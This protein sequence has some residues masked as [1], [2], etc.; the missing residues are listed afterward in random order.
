MANKKVNL[1][2]IGQVT[3]YKN[4]RSRSIRIKVRSNHDTLVT[5]PH[6]MPYKAAL[7]FVN[8]Q[9]DWIIKQQQQAAVLVDKQ[10]IG[11]AHHLYFRHDQAAN[12]VRSRVNQTEVIVTLPAQ[13]EYAG[14]LAQSTAYQA[15]IKA[16]KNESQT[17]LPQRL[18]L[19][20]EGGSFVYKDVHT[21]NL[22]SRWGSCSQDNT[23]GLN[24]F[25]M[26][27]PW[28]LIDYV[29]LHELAHTRV[30]NHS[31]KF[32]DE[33]SKYAP[34][35]KQLRRQLHSFHPDFNY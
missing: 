22:K 35:Y 14:Q 16:L 17:L 26:K 11:K 23:I 8:S 7:N 27:L 6:W 30:H 20:A 33:L 32:W 2:L 12:S 10:A 21:R 29:L 24:I 31:S 18:R 15:C 5:L 34:N 9:T 13:I 25:L 4:R 19:L 1:P 3:L 28:Q